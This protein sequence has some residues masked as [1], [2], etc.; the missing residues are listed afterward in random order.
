MGDRLDASAL[1]RRYATSMRRARLRLRPF[2]SLRHFFASMAVSKATLVQV[3]PWMGDS[4]IQTTA[5][6][7]AIASRAVTPPCL[8]TPS[9]PLAFRRCQIEPSAASHPLL[10]TASRE[11]PH[12]RVTA[13]AR[14]E[15][16]RIWNGGSRLPDHRSPMPAGLAQRLCVIVPRISERASTARL[17]RDQPVFPLKARSG[18]LAV[19]RVGRT[20]IT[21]SARPHVDA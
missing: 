21:R 3:H 10:I 2:H 20:R 17:H 12:G 5:Q 19:A 8:L 9:V 11:A 4:H 15:R 16:S 14:G 18:E 6:Y 13:C 1:R 7:L